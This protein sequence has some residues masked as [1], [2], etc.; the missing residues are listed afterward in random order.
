MNYITSYLQ[1]KINWDLKI[2]NRVL[3][4]RQKTIFITEDFSSLLPI[5]VLDIFIF[6]I[7]FH[8]TGFNAWRRIG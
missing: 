6:N 7:V 8:M 4:N 3:Q 2:I 1:N 5:Y